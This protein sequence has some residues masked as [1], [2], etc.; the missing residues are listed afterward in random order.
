[1]SSPFRVRPGLGLAML[2]ALA[3]CGR[4][5]RDYRSTA[6]QAQARA[7]AFEGNAWHIAQGQRLFAWMIWKGR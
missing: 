6:M 2:L 7:A 1:M 3:S 5:T 4:E